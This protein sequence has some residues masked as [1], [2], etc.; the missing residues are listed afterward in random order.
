MK[1]RA[2]SNAL[3]ESFLTLNTI[4]DVRNYLADLCTP[5]E[6]AALTERLEIAILLSEKNLS[7]R[8]ISHRT[9]ASTTTVA[10]VARF[11]NDE[12]HGGYR[13]TIQKLNQKDKTNATA[14]HQSTPG[15]GRS[16]RTAG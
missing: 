5:Q 9:G 7:Y 11:L 15:S 14:R 10:R 13:K 2:P 16:Q 3:L 12:P 6:I 1:A 8:D 4:Q